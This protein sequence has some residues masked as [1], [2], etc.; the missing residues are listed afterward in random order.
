MSISGRVMTGWQAMLLNVIREGHDRRA[1]NVVRISG[2]VMTGRQCYRMVLGRVI[3]GRQCC[4]NVI[5]IGEVTTG[6]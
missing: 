6:K 1:S 5:T 4:Q 2:R 3:T